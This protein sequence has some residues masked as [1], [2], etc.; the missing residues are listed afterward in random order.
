[1]SSNGII[2]FWYGIIY[3]CFIRIN[4]LFNQE[5]MQLQSLVEILQRS[6]KIRIR[7]FRGILRNPTYNPQRS[8]LMLQGS[9]WTLQRSSRTLQRSLYSLQRSSRILVQDVVE[10]PKRFFKTFLVVKDLDDCY[11]ERFAVTDLCNN[12]LYVFVFSALSQKRIGVK[13]MLGVYLVMIAGMVV[14]FMTLLAEIYWSNRNE[15]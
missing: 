9:M 10:D 12:K 4:E 2:Y 8:C 11:M 14:A 1:M 7:I 5:V 15:V 3:F 13:S 6:L